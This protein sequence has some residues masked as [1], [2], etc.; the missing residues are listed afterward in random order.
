MGR[1]QT[2]LFPSKGSFSLFWPDFWEPRTLKRCFLENSELFSCVSQGTWLGFPYSGCLHSLIFNLIQSGREDS[3]GA[4]SWGQERSF[5]AKRKD[6]NVP[7]NS[8]TR[9][10]FLNSLEYLKLSTALNRKFFFFLFFF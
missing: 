3:K 1:A 4:G 9:F 2:Y 8:V 7:R 10:H 6:A 5:Q